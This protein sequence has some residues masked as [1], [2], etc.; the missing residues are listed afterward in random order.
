MDASAW[1]EGFYE[2]VRRFRAARDRTDVSVRIT[3]ADDRNMFVNGLW[4]GPGPNHL[5]IDPYPESDD[6]MVTTDEGQ[7]V[8]PTAMIVPLSSVAS[9]ELMVD[10]PEDRQVGFTAPDPP[11]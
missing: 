6:A 7:L 8:T 4:A 9:V 1:V 2:A 3:L 5:T 11:G 10:V